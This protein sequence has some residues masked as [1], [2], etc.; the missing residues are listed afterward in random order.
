MPREETGETLSLVETVGRDGTGM[1]FF[2]WVTEGSREGAL[3]ELVDPMTEEAGELPGE[4]ADESR[5][6]MEESESRSWS[7]EALERSRSARRELRSSMSLST[8]SHL[9]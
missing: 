4:R 5:E 1:V 3:V 6:M 2:F 7:R 8:L 9:P